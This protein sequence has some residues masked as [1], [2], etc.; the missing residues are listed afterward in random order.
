MRGQNSSL[1]TQFILFTISKVLFSRWTWISCFFQDVFFHL[2]CK[3]SCGSI[4]DV[5]NH[6]AV[7]AWVTVITGKVSA[8][9][10]S[11]ASVSC[12]CLLFSL[13]VALFFFMNQAATTELPAVVKVYQPLYKQ[14]WQAH[15]NTDNVSHPTICCDINDIFPRINKL[16]RQTTEH[17]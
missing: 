10:W 5:F 1:H 12:A 13:N 15:N 11:H 2:L 17:F 16:V 9:Q 4:S 8:S 14:V 3:F 7:S 6:D